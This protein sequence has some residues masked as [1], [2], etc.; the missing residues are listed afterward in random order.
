MNVSLLA[1]LAMVP[2]SGGMKVS[3]APLWKL[4]P[5]IVIVWLLADA[6][7]EF[8]AILLMAGPGATT[9]KALDRE[10]APAAV[11]TKNCHDPLLR[12]TFTSVRLVE[13]FTVMPAEGC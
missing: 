1:V 4:L 11:W 12:L 2:P 7:Y 10:D 13:L 5:L 6:G 9:L 3:V 8:G